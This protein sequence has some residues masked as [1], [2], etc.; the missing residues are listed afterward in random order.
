MNRNPF[1]SFL[2]SRYFFLNI[3][4]GIV[5]IALIFFAFFKSLDFITHHGEEIRVP[6]VIGQDMTSGIKALESMKFNVS[7]DS[8]FR[9]GKKGGEILDQNPAAGEMVKENRTIYLTLVKFSAPLVH[10]PSFEDRPFKEFESNL[11]G[12]GLDIDSITYVP[13]IAKDLV[14]GVRFEGKKLSSGESIPKGSKVSLLL[15]DGLGGNM[16]LLPNLIGLRLDEARFAVRGSQLV[17]GSV[18][19]RGI[20]TDSNFAK[21]VEQIPARGT[22]SLAKVSQGSVIN[23]ILEQKTN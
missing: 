18:T 16:V 13:D 10:L 23:V 1:I 17:L 9:A 15:G 7:I 11:K 3:G 12:I 4:L 22:D 2:K 8:V 19:Y 21:I 5:F 6:G 14:L 20:I